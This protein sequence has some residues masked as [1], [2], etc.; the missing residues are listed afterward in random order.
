MNLPE[1]AVAEQLAAQ[2]LAIKPE[3]LPA[4]VR[5]RAEELLI[6]VIGLSVAA[7]NTDYVRAVIGGVDVG[8]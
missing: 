3:A 7:R 6:D 8:A 5:D 2:A 1:T 4:A